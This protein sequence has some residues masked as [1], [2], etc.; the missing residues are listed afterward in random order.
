MIK[1]C[2]RKGL[3]STKIETDRQYE[4]E[5]NLFDCFESASSTTILYE[6]LLFMQ[7]VRK[8]PDLGTN[9][10]SYYPV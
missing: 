10:K 9:R 6:N 8:T 5:F 1:G 7:Y 3:V 2:E 4:E